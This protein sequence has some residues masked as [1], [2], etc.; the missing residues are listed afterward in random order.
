M[1]DNL[2]NESGNLTIEVASNAT[3]TSINIEDI[4]DEMVNGE[5][6]LRR[7]T[8]LPFITRD[9]ST[10]DAAM[11][12]R[13]NFVRPNFDEELIPFDFERDVQDDDDDTMPDLIPSEE[14][15]T[16][17]QMDNFILRMLNSHLD[18]EEERDFE[19]RTLEELNDEYR[20]LFEEVDFW[21]IFDEPSREEIHKLNHSDILE[22]DFEP[23]IFNMEDYG[24]SIDEITGGNEIEEFEYFNFLAFT[25]FFFYLNTLREANDWN[26]FFR[27]GLHKVFD[28]KAFDSIRTAQFY[29]KLHYYIR[30]TFKEKYSIAVTIREINEMLNHYESNADQH[31]LFASIML[32]VLSK[33]DDIGH[34][35]I[36]IVKKAKTFLTPPRSP[37]VR[38]YMMVSSAYVIST[39][40]GYFMGTEG[41]HFLIIILT[42]LMQLILLKDMMKRNLFAILICV[43]IEEIWRTPL[44]FAL[45]AQAKIPMILQ[46]NLLPLPSLVM[47]VLFD[48]YMPDLYTRIL[49]HFIFNSSVFYWYNKD[50]LEKGFWF[51]ILYLLFENAN[52]NTNMACL[53]SPVDEEDYCFEECCANMGAYDISF[54]RKLLANPHNARHKIRVWFR[55]S[56]K[57]RKL[58]KE[59]LMNQFQSGPQG[60]WDLLG[61]GKLTEALSKHEDFLTKLTESVVVPEVTKC[62]ETV[63]KFQ[64]SGIN[65]NVGVFGLLDIF[66]Q[67]QHTLPL[68]I[69]AFCT[70]NVLEEK[71][72]GLGSFKLLKLLILSAGG[73]VISQQPALQ[74]MLSY[75]TSTLPQ[76]NEGLTW[77]GLVAEGI[78]IMLFGTKL[79]S[80][81]LSH[82]GDQMSKIVRN[83]RDSESLIDKVIDWCKRLINAI[84]SKFGIDLSDWFETNDVR[85]KELQKEVNELMLE[86]VHN[87]MNV[88]MTFS[89][90]VTR[91]TMRVNDMISSIPNTPE[92]NVINSILNRLSKDLFTL[93]RIAAEAGLNMGSRYDPACV[94]V[95]GAPGCGKSYKSEF[96]AIDYAIEFCSKEQLSDILRSPKSQIYSWPVDGKHHDQYVGQMVT[97][98]PDLF[99]QTDA[100]GQPSEAVYIVYLISST[101]LNLLAAELMKKQRIWFISDIVLFNSNQ[102]RLYPGMFKSLRN[103]DAVIRRL[104]EHCYYQWCDPRVAM[105]GTRGEILRHESTQV[106]QGY[107]HDD[108]LYGR[109]DPDKIKNFDEDEVI[110]YRKFDISTGAFADDVILNQSQ[111]QAVTKKY[112]A[113]K[114]TRGEE[115]K[116]AIDK[117]TR[118]LINRRGEFHAQ[119]EIGITKR[120]PTFY[121]R[122]EETED[123]YETCDAEPQGFEG[124]VLPGVFSYEVFAEIVQRFQTLMGMSVNDYVNSKVYEDVEYMEREIT[125]IEEIT[126]ES[127]MSYYFGSMALAVFRKMLCM[128][129]QDAVIYWKQF[130]GID[131]LT[132]LNIMKRC[133]ES[134]NGFFSLGKGGENFLSN[135]AHVLWNYIKNPEILQCLGMCG[136]IAVGF[137]MAL[138]AYKLAVKYIIPEENA[139]P[140][141]DSLVPGEKFLV[142]YQSN[143]MACFVIHK[144]G[145]RHPCNALMIGDR[146]GVT[147]RHMFTGMKARLTMKPGDIFTLGLV[148]FAGGT[149]KDTT[150][151]YDFN[152]VEWFDDDEEL[153]NRDLIVFKLPDDAR[154]PSLKRFIPPKKALDYLLNKGNLS[155]TFCKVGID[156]EKEALGSVR[157]EQMLLTVS[158]RLCT[159]NTSALI[160]NIEYSTGLVSLKAW[161]AKSRNNN[162][163]TEVGD[164]ASICVITDERKNYCVNLDFPQA[165]SEW[166]AYLHVAISDSVAQGVPIYRELFDR[167]FEMMKLPQ[168]ETIKERLDSQLNIVNEALGINSS[169][170]ECQLP[171]QE[172]NV[173]LDKYHRSVLECESLFSSS[174]KSMIKRS[175][176]YGID[177]VTRKPARLHD[178]VGEDGRVSIMKQAR[179]PYGSNDVVYDQ[180]LIRR[181]IHDA[182]TH[183]YNSSR[184]TEKK[185]VLTLDQALYGDPAYSLGAIKKSSSSGFIMRVLKH[186]LNLKGKGK[187]WMYEGDRLSG[188]FENII[189][190]I[191]DKNVEKL[192]K[193]ERIFN[194]YIDNL[195]DE[196]VSHEKVKLGKTRLFCSADLIYLILSRMYFGA[197]AGWIFENRI[198][199]GIAIGINPYS[200]EWDKSAEHLLRNSIKMIFGDYS[201]FDKKQ[202]RVLMESCLVLMNLFYGEEGKQERELLFEEIVDS[203]H[204][205]IEDGKFYFYTWDHGNTSGN[206]LT[207]I[208]NSLVNI[209]II[210]IVAVYAQ[211]IY[212]GSPIS[213]DI[214][215]DFETI[216]RNVS[217][218]VLGDDVVLSVSDALPYLTFNTYKLICGQLLGLDFTDELK[219]DGVIPDYR[220]IEEGSFLG[221]KFR[222]GEWLG[223]PKWWCPLRLYSVIECV[224]WIKGEFD[225]DIEISKFEGLNLEMSERTEKEFLDIVPRY[226]QACYKQYGKLP[227]YTDY[228]V[229]R[230]KVVGMSTH[231]YSFDTFLVRQDQD[232]LG[233]NRILEFQFMCEQTD[234]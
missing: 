61:V 145:N 233:L 14:N 123:G 69:I 103:M 118:K 211:L 18:F 10:F 81:D 217:Y 109:I 136:K 86:N 95:V 126:K 119:E 194:I 92:N 62:R 90:R 97:M 142:K 127:N 214:D 159:Y 33:L 48:Y 179:E 147:V 70:I 26:F 163:R 31:K 32:K 20:H 166:I 91:L 177:P 171:M 193:G 1:S 117:Y 120:D 213:G 212:Q 204:V 25:G 137:G 200:R 205:V 180:V 139:T 65:V 175:P 208:L 53:T 9:L 88:T 149:L 43:L 152:R 146:F 106:V 230:A 98:F 44:I 206:F 174:T 162:F 141:V 51:M 223:S 220:S 102:L 185:E 94:L 71:Y 225:P 13:L 41:I 74:S 100:E 168:Y 83:M 135:S 78:Q 215:Y 55:H 143:L 158:N 112:I 219:T 28:I 79:I 124:E 38:N 77:I 134:I 224:Q 42:I 57:Q 63:E 201:K 155:A 186:R 11:E 22:D 47:H 228:Q 165:A 187:S 188:K 169:P 138:A 196:L 150:L 4:N 17:Q 30:S 16:E 39:I 216:A 154:Y 50:K 12:I 52:F 19:N 64:E 37:R 24:E 114:K 189:R 21:H 49:L 40:Y 2:A 59:S 111:Y 192:R 7:F 93:Q 122:M 202:K 45:E 151:K 130:K 89:E 226:A 129:Y 173:E 116:V 99:S 183:V 15:L 110:F 161:A 207:A 199:N 82:L 167:Y 34:N 221:R 218:L 101:P 125:F 73:Y 198:D 66:K 128:K 170:E 148:P 96:N 72:G 68:L 133:I 132:S 184:S 84:S 195:K 209:S 80:C 153:K 6:T 46:G 3:T 27:A 115:R 144:D 203:L 140:Q 234:L 172:S 54:I 156:R 76:S 5:L 181:V 190:H 182:M 222:L 210:F 35:V 36:E 191:I 160:D 56:H 104:N 29:I 60:D 8:N 178:F 231:Q 131:T 113:S 58:L 67:P 121:K 232:S 85:I 107:E 164:C 227:K 87:P 176:I 105:T 157:Y 229:A 23:T 75:W 197:F 108:Y